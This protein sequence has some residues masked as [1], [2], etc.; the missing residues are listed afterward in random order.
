M[1]IALG[2]EATNNFV[3]T[4]ETKL[5]TF[6]DNMRTL[7]STVNIIDEANAANEQISKK[8]LKMY[9]Q[10]YAEV[11]SVSGAQLPERLAPIMVECEK[12]L[13]TTATV[14]DAELASHKL[15][16]EKAAKDSQMKF[17]VRTSGGIIENIEAV[18]Q[19]GQQVE[20]TFAANV[21]KTHASAHSNHSRQFEAMTDE[22]QEK[23]LLLTGDDRVEHLRQNFEAKS[24]AATKQNI[25]GIDL[26]NGLRSTAENFTENTAECI[27][28]CGNDLRQ[29]R[30]KGFRAYESTGGTPIKR[31]YKA[32]VRLVATEPH[33]Q[34]KEEICRKIA[35]GM[36]LDCSIVDE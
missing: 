12:Q 24:M 28:Q 36:S 30:E 21:L 33:E 15:Q 17:D 31:N 1:Q 2:I 7:I 10:I 5:A 9:D 25:E 32:N 18:L 35:Q 13:L 23:Q 26:M 27:R 29:F 22:M 6:R 34:I 4:M 16:I 20:D 14:C 11:K 19:E 8:L 3:L